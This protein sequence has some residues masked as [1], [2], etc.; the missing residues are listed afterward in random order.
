MTNAI[1]PTSLPQCPTYEGNGE[2][3]R[4]PRVSFES[5]VGPP[6]SRKRSTVKM[7]RMPINMVMTQE[8]VLTFE[9]FYD[10]VIGSGA[11]SFMFPHPRL[12]TQVQAWIASEDVQIV[13]IAPMHY[14]VTFELLLV[15]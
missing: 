15:Q 11:N 13:K 12:Q 2:S 6:I 9:D 8:Q 3:L 10:N 1:W 14:Q 7:S 4:R 5:E